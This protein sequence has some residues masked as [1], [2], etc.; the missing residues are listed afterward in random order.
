MMFTCAF[1][2]WF[3][4]F[5][6]GFYSVLLHLRSNATDLWGFVPGS[7]LSFPLLHFLSLSSLI[8]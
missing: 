4:S 2:F 7:F 3:F 8:V 1:F 6:F 5:G